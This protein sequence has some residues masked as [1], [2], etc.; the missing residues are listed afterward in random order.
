LIQNDNFTIILRLTNWG[1]KIAAPIFLERKNMTILDEID[2][3]G[4]LET[5][6]KNQSRHFSRNTGLEREYLYQAGYLNVI[7]KCKSSDV[8]YAVN[9]SRWG[10]QALVRSE[11]RE[12]QALREYADNYKFLHPERRTFEGLDDILAELSE[13]NRTLMELWLQGSLSNRQI[14]KEVGRCPCWCKKQIIK[15]CKEISEI[16]GENGLDVAAIFPTISRNLPKGIYFQYGKYI[17]RGGHAGKDY[18]GSFD[19]LESAKEAKLKKIKLN[20]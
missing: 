20:K 10:M 2:D 15:I 18:Y 17:V 11:Q 1:S 12:K 16:V 7:E 13:E 6:I 14:G 8:Q 5:R 3:L 9:C 19:D 4:L